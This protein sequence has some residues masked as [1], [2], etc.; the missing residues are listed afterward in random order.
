MLLISMEG[1]IPQDK[2]DRSCLASCCCR[3]VKSPTWNAGV[4]TQARSLRESASGSPPSSCK[5]NAASSSAS[6]HIQSPYNDSN[7]CSGELVGT[8]Q[9]PHTLISFFTCSFCSL[10]FA[11]I[12]PVA[13]E[14][15]SV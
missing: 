2:K 4:S 9:F 3:A 11:I 6:I 1:D 14:I 10:L 13:G 5:C 12:N 8:F 7:Y 15:S